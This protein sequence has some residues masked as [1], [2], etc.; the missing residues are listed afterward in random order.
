M[1]IA[2]INRAKTIAIPLNSSSGNSMIT[3]YESSGLAIGSEFAPGYTIVSY[4]VFVKNLK[5]FSQ[6]DSLPEI[7]LPNFDIADSETDKLYKTLNVEWQSARKQ[8]NLFISDGNNWNQVGS[9]SILN[10]S[11]YPFRIYSL[12]DMFTDNLYF[13]L[14]ENGKIGVQMQ[15]VNYGLLTGNDLIVIHGSYVEEIFLESQEAPIAINVTAAIPTTPIIPT[16]PTIPVTPIGVDEDMT[17]WIIKNSGYAA[18]VGDKIL[19]DA[20]FAP[21]LIV[22]LPPYPIPGSTIRV[23]AIGTDNAV[24]DF[25]G[26]NLDGSTAF[27]V[28]LPTRNTE[29]VL[30]YHSSTFGWMS[31]LNLP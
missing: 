11:G 2:P 19:M 22:M 8:L 16:I 24:L 12:L 9:T 31:N 3:I 4:N 13:E 18:A 25:N 15:D 28:P 5:A 17:N 26:D 30:V 29:Y 14:G 21:G 7:S 23:M 10:P 20:R 27:T 1:P 6:I